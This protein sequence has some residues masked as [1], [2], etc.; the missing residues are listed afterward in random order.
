MKKLSLVLIT[1]DCLRADHVG[2]LG[3]PRPTTPFL[4]TLARESIVFPCALVPGAPTYFSFPGIMAAR[5]P[6]VL[7]R[8]TVGIA[9]GEPT[10]P[11]VLQA[12]G[13]TTVGFVAGNPYL[14]GRFGYDQGFDQF[15]DF[16]FAGDSGARDSD[17]GRNWATRVNEGLENASRKTGL[18]AAAYQELYFR[19]CQWLASR[20]AETMD[21]LRPYPA[22]DVVV[23]QARSWLSGVGDQPFFM[24]LHLMDPH[25]PY[26][27]SEKALDSFDSRVTPRRARFLNS[28]WNRDLPER[29]LRRHRESIISLYDAGIRW[30]DTHLSHLVHALRQFGRWNDT[31]FALTA[32]HGEEFLEHGRRYHSPLALPETLI[33]VPLLLRMPG[34]QSARLPNAPFSLVDL[35]PTLLEAMGIAPPSTFRGTSCWPQV[36]NGQLP[37]RPVVT[38]CI[39]GNLNPVR[40]EDCL[41][42]RILATR[43]GSYKLVIRFADSSS[44]L[45]NLDSDPQE[46]SPI[47]CA[48]N[49]QER[50]RLLLHAREHLQK[51]R[52]Y[53]GSEFR[54]RER[55]RQFRH[56]M[57]VSPARIAVGQG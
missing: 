28:F 23:D 29:R 3:Y 4:D 15:H 27:P 53:S 13:W 45:F 46:L 43:Q 14:T 12:H 52:G 54:M 51:S 18:T 44:A 37:D 31:M 26:F 40:A 47:P 36:L 24:W 49:V 17:T 6:L 57:A 22:A 1:V 9:P 35:A 20:R 10:L 55:L 8:D 32:D 16:L 50:R 11:S 2:F 19:Y 42:P 48:Q 21:N 39:D 7:G 56:S 33:R 34:V 30:V 38:E 41:R 25:H 5:H